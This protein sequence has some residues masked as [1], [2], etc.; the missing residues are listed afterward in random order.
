MYEVLKVRK[1]KVLKLIV[2]VLS[3]I[4]V[5]ESLFFIVLS[6]RPPVKTTRFFKA[7]I[8]IVLDDWGYNLNNLHIA[9][10]MQYPFTAAIL[11]NLTYSATVA[12][13]LHA[14]GFEIVLHLP[15]EP[16][17]PIRLE[18]DTI[19]TSFNEEAINRIIAQD[20]SRISYAKG[21]SNH[22]G[23]KATQNKKTMEVLFKELEKR[24]LFFLDSFVTSKSVCSVLAK[25]CCVAVLKRDV[26][27]DN[28]QDASYIK[29]QI[30]VLKQ[31]ARVKGFA[32]GIGH[33]RRLTLEVLKEV[34]PQIERE[35][36][37]FVFLSELL[38]Y[39]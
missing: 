13:E 1:E 26:F 21:V 33:D 5:I 34:M 23:S 16:A 17:E 12:R 30:N 3:V 4:V 31:Q 2:W 7:R 15:M 35:G 14:R 11:P 29:Q 10:Q 36:Y 8:A 27:L 9:K 38:N 37:K 19:L 32:V 6:K 24:N 28:R 20:L 22:M 39:V 18:K 25:K